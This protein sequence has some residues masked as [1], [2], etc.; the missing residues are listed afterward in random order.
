MAVEKMA[1]EGEDLMI[2]PPPAGTQNKKKKHI[3]RRYQGY[4]WVI[5]SFVL[6]LI[7]SYYP[8]VAAFFYSLTDWNG[9]QFNFTGIANFTRLFQDEAFFRS[10]GSM[11]I[12]LIVGMVAGNIMTIIL[13]ELLF[14]LKSTK[15]SNALRFLFILPILVPGLVS[16]LMWTKVIFSPAPSGLM[17]TIFRWF[18]IPNSSWYYSEKTVLISIIF[19][20]FPWVA[21]TSFLIYLAGLQSIPESVFEAAE[22]DGITIWKRLIYIDLPMIRSQIKYFVVLGIIG[23]IQNYSM[24]FAV[25]KPGPDNPAMVPGYYMYVS[26]FSYSE[27]GYACAIGLF[28]FIIILVVTI[29]NNKFMKTTEVIS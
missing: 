1:A 16:M 17:N 11:L 26:A 4:L 15:A 24:Q 23:G 6:L 27:Y 8:P 7:F 20:G 21:G 2:S 14:N 19:T 28:L 18:G 9:V 25:I 3:F 5:P 10:M 13:A 29:I 12:L 22:L